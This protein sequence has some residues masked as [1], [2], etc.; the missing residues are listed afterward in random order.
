MAFPNALYSNAIDARVWYNHIH[1]TAASA[2]A[3]LGFFVPYL[4]REVILL[5][6]PP[7]KL[8]A[9]SFS[10]ALADV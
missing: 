3:V 9:T 6:T 4:D 5:P 2:Y 8:L 10:L 7:Y 1:S